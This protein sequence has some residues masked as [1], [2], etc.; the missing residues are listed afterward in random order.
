VIKLDEEIPLKPELEDAPL[1]LYAVLKEEIAVYDM[2]PKVVVELV[3]DTPTIE[4]IDRTEEVVKELL[5][6]T[7][8]FVGRAN[9]DEAIT[10]LVCVPLKPDKIAIVDAID[11]VLLW[12]E[13]ELLCATPELEAATPLDDDDE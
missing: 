1:T 12:V 6:T 2:P 4:L 8:E 3:E 10:V 11:I 5:W 9:E 13:G 7:I